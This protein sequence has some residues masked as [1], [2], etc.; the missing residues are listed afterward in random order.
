[1][2]RWLLFFI[3]WCSTPQNAL[4][5]VPYYQDLFYGG[6]T[7]D[8]YSSI[9]LE[10]TDT[11]NIFIEPGSSIKKGILFIN[12]ATNTSGILENNLI[13]F[14]GIQID[15]NINNALVDFYTDAAGST[16]ALHNVLA[17]DVTNLISPLDNTYTLKPPVNQDPT[18]QRT[19][20]AQYYL[21]VAYEN[22]ALP[23]VSTSVFL[24]NLDSDQTVAYNFS[25]LNSI[26]PS[27]DAGFTF[28]G[29]AFCD[30]SS[31]GSFVFVNGNPIGLVGGPESP[32]ELV[33]GGVR[34]AFYYQNNTLFGLDNDVK[35]L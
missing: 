14:N 9:N 8:G 26:D 6:V 4:S 32:M 1:M 21:F 13:M 19:L 25:D 7:G 31:D 18:G 29:W 33:C 22:A 34:G 15:L 3:L 11:L 20:Y 30:T 5:Q 17:I 10:T 24:N 16:L 27:F 23:L 2:F 35:G 12:T 28:M